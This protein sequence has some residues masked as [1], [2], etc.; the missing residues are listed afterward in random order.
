MLKEENPAL[1][2]RTLSVALTGHWDICSLNPGVGGIFPFSVT[3][4]LLAK[5][6]IV[7]RCPSARLGLQHMLLWTFSAGHC[8]ALITIANNITAKL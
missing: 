5:S 2:E 7:L 8:K 3:P 1:L 6:N 4:Y